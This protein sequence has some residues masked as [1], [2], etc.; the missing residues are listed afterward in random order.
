M[1]IVVIRRI[2]LFAIIFIGFIFYSLGL[3]IIA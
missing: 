3:G 1:F 2:W